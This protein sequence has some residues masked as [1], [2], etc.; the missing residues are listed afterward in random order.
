VSQRHKHRKPFFF[1][2]H[3]FF[4]LFFSKEC[5]P[6]ITACDITEQVAISHFNWLKFSVNLSTVMLLARFY[7]ALELEKERQ[8]FFCS[9][10]GRTVLISP[11]K[12]SFF[13][14]DTLNLTPCTAI[15]GK[16][17]PRKGHEGPDGEKRYSTTLSLTSALD[18]GA[19]FFNPRPS[20]FSHGRDPVPTVC[21]GG[22]V[23]PRVVLDG[24]GKSR[25]RVYNRQCHCLSLNVT[26]VLLYPVYYN[27]VF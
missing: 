20:R 24:Y 25:S 17:H 9:V 2:N 16:V 22:W 19:C 7:N 23:G 27:L 12:E 21:I 26:S 5:I 13:N 10:M 1:R 14:V 4:F 3:P 6:K 11:K 8:K 18:G 15:K